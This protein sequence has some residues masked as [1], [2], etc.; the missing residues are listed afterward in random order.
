MRSLLAYDNVNERSFAAFSPELLDHLAKIARESTEEFFRRKP[1]W[2]PYRDRLLCIALAQGAARH[3]LDGSTGVKDIDVW[4]FYEFDR[5]LGP[6]PYRMRWTKDFGPSVFG[7][8]PADEGYEGRRV[9]LLNR[10]I[11][12]PIGASR[13]EALRAYLLDPRTTT[14][15]LL[16][17]KPVV[18]LDPKDRRGEIVYQP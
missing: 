13:I 8:H 14:A 4:I 3:Y 10:S 15:R 18:L 5:Q 9:D 16:A 11:M 6:F 2:L 17:Q 7:R 12:R 1:R